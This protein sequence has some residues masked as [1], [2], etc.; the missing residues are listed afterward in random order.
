V[1]VEQ[2]TTQKATTKAALESAFARY[3]TIAPGDVF[4]FYVASHGTVAGEDL[5]SRGYF[6]IPSN[7]NTITDEA[8]RRDAL[9]EDELKQ[10]IA[11][12][13]A[14]RKLL[15]LDTCHAGAMGDAMMLTTRG[16]EEIAAVKVLSGA[17][18]STVLSASTSDQEAL[19]GQDG[20][21]LFTWVL[22]QGLG[23][24]AD[25]R[26]HGY[27]NTFDLADYVDDEVPR[28]AEQHFKRKQVPNLHNAGQSFQIVSS[29]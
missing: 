26:K 13:P 6:L 4:V 3:R 27:I 8:I 17:V 28:I 5:G 14:T 11:S 29:N 18:G 9:S 7:V 15:L 25:F 24:S 2:L 22:L 19:E 20:H 23:G 1:N 21:G 16:L 12:I 10:M